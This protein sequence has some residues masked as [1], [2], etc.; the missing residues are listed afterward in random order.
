M[1]E[2]VRHSFQISVHVRVGGQLLNVAARSSK[3]D[4]APAEVDVED[5]HGREDQAADAD[6]DREADG[7]RVGLR[8]WS[9]WFDDRGLAVDGR[10]VFGAPDGSVIVVVVVVVVWN[11]NLILY[12]LWKKKYFYSSKQIEKY[13]LGNSKENLEKWSS[14]RKDRQERSKE[15]KLIIK[16]TKIKQ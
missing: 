12:V 5:Q 15:K 1:A 16:D 3:P 11:G 6:S 7:E 9:R 13:G 10:V 8:R 14:E 4:V 2:P